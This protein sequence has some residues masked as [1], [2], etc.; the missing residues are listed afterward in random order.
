MNV[1][2][3]D[4]AKFQRALKKEIQGKLFLL[5]D[6]SLK[7]KIDRAVEAIKNCINAAGKTTLLRYVST[8]VGKMPW[9]DEELER[10]KTDLQTAYKRWKRSL[11]DLSREFN[12]NQYIKA[13][14]KHK[15][16]F[17]S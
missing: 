4:W 17:Y 1:K 7:N 15:K 11:T 12:Y 6:L 13:K 16:L 9:I 10:A 8:W 2:G 5:D 14:K 3:V